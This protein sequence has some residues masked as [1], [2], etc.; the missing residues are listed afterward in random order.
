MTSFPWSGRQQQFWG[1]FTDFLRKHQSKLHREFKLDQNRLYFR[2]RAFLQKNV[3]VPFRPAFNLQQENPRFVD[4]L[5]SN[6][7]L[8]VK[9]Q[10]RLSWICAWKVES[11][12]PFTPAM[13]RHPVRD[14][15][16]FTLSVCCGLAGAD[17][18]RLLFAEG[19]WI[20]WWSFEK[21]EG[22]KNLLLAS[23]VLKRVQ[24][25]L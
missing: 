22:L 13:R 14:H 11:F 3:W 12:E 24:F 15:R 8:K 1:I 18:R 9:Q 6:S 10:K 5:L 19:F 17:T 2:Q 23:A 20:S 7:R 16:L 21:L 4:V 25:H